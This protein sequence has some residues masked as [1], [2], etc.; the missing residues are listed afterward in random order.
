MTTKRISPLNNFWSVFLDM[1]AL[2]E[3]VVSEITDLADQIE[4]QL[5]GISAMADPTTDLA[6]NAQADNQTV[7]E[8]LYKIDRKFDS[9]YSIRS[10]II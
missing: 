2:S 10:L 7:L 6:V 1:H 3:L 5:S 4:R 8:S 9:W